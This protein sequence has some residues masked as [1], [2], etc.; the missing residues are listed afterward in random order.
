MAPTSSPM[1]PEHVQQP[2]ETKRHLRTN[3]ES[4]DLE[5]TLEDSREIGAKG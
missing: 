5:G 1:R 2:Q 3:R 4:G